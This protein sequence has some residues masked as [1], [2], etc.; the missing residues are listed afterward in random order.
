LFTLANKKEKG[1]HEG[2]N[3]MAGTYGNKGNRSRQY[4]F[5]VVE[6][7]IAKHFE[8]CASEFAR[9]LSKV[10]KKDISRQMVQGWRNRAQFSRDI[11]PSVNLLTGVPVHDLIISKAPVIE[12]DNEPVFTAQ[13]PKTSVSLKS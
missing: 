3:K 8:G 6:F 1:Y 12:A 2:K 13:S 11:I 7:V 10:A 4:G 5:N 9:Q